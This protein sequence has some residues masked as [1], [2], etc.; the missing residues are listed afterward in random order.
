MDEHPH[1]S[2][3]YR[4]TS[5]MTRSPAPL[6]PE[7]GDA[8]TYAE[9]IGNGVTPRRLRHHR[10]HKPTRGL[11]LVQPPADLAARAVAHLKVLPAGRCAYSHAT[12]AQLLGLPGGCDHRLHVTLKGG[13]FV[14]RPGIVMHHGLERR[15][16][17][18][19]AGLPVIAP[20]LTWLDLAPTSDLEE[21]VVLG[22][23]IL[24]REPGLAEALH[25]TVADNCGARGIKR[26]MH[27]L[28]LIRP[29]VLSAQESLWRLRFRA[30]GF[31]EPE[32]NVT[33][34]DRSGR[35]LGVGD[36]V[37]RAQ[38]VVAEYDGDYHFTVEQRRLDQT[39]RRA[40]RGGDCAVIEI[41]GAD[42]RNPGPALRATGDALS[43]RR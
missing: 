5:A 3:V 15:E 11:R 28:E 27:A 25:Q 35:W 20:V 23:A 41:N 4:H 39:R 30:A 13:C 24:H 9:A 10:L 37:W 38:R 32:L 2:W 34:R 42:N 33:V 14:R 8:F 7:L 29:G 43:G 1:G 36:S 22:D 31:P 26:A 21:M 12:A 16:I 17:W 40:M 6:P 19:V 18:Y